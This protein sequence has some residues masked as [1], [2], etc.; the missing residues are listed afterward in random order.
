MKDDENPFS[1]DSELRSAHGLTPRP[2]PAFDHV[3]NLEA[4]Q[5][6]LDQFH[7]DMNRALLAQGSVT[8]I[9]GLWLGLVLEVSWGIST[10]IAVLCGLFTGLRIMR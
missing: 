9:V 3:K 4:V 10:P 2:P 1:Y 7:R 5:A 6:A 8:L